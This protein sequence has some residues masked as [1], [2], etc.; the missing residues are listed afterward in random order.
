[1]LSRWR[2][3]RVSSPQLPPQTDG[4]VW[5]F[6]AQAPRNGC[7]AHPLQRTRSFDNTHF[8]F[9]VSLASLTLYFT[10]ESHTLSGNMSCVCLIPGPGV[11]VDHLCQERRHGTLGIERICSQVFLSP[12]LLCS[13]DD[14]GKFS[15]L[16]LAFPVSAL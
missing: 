9:P 5:F 2:H 3:F 14:Q 8:S 6:L 10:W 7:T 11:D 4:P 12:D 16:L 13:I 1:M 15:P